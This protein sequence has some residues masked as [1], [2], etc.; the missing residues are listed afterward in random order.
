ME[1]EH[2]ELMKKY[3]ENL[4][5]F[6]E[7]IQAQDCVRRVWAVEK[8]EE[9]STKLRHIDKQITYVIN[10]FG[11]KTGGVTGEAKKVWPNGN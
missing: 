6:R 7:L 4:R 2:L 8:N 5:L 9:I 11:S 3:E 10:Y 1:N